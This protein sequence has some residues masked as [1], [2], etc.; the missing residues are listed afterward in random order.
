MRAAGGLRA[1]LESQQELTK[2]YTRLVF[3]KAKHEVSKK[4]DQS[5]GE[6]GKSASCARMCDVMR[7]NNKEEIKKT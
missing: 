1:R 3:R 4:A 6:G 2:K 7:T 5:Y